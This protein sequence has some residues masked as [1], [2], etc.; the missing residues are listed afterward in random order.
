[1]KRNLLFVALL[2]LIIILHSCESS[3]KV[4][5]DYDKAANFSQ[6]KTFSVVQM[7]QQNQSISQ[8]NQNRI[9]NAVKSELTKKGLQ[10]SANPDLL[11]NIVTILK[12]KQSVTANSNY[13]GYGGAY[14]PYSWG[15]GM[16]SGY[17]T[18]D[19][20]EYKDGSIIVELVDAKQKNLVWEGIGNK[21]IDKP[22]SDPDKAISEAIAAILAKYPPGAKK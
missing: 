6:Y 3:L 7:D 5:S 9:I 22:A 13:Y 14:R 21:E 19:V 15:G 8:L 17:T 4:T 20:H 18:Y 2:G 12:D 16:A 10:E 11:V 1:M